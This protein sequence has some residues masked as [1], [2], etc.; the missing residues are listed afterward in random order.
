MSD[1]PA[2]PRSSPTNIAR[3]VFVGELS[4]DGA[5]RHTKGV[6]PMPASTRE[7]GSDSAY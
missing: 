6:P 7:Q 1:I 2:Y 5:V 3:A 4:L